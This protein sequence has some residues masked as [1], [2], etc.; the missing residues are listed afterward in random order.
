MLNVLCVAA[1][2]VPASSPEQQ[3]LDFNLHTSHTAGGTFDR[4]AFLSVFR[5]ASKTLDLDPYKGISTLE[6]GVDALFQVGGNL[7]EAPG[8]T[9]VHHRVD[10]PRRDLKPEYDVILSGILS[11][12]DVQDLLEV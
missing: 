11:E 9:M 5:D 8:Q 6:E 2:R 3:S 12:S 1:S 10:L 7:D 4:T